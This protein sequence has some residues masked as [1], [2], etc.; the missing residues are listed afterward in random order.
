MW[1]AGVV[2]L[3]DDDGWDWSKYGQRPL[4]KSRY[5]IKH[6]FRVRPCD[7][8]LCLRRSEAVVNV[9]QQGIL[10]MIVTD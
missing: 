7:C 9:T 5:S 2:L 4:T 6:Y 3:L 1:D 8:V 10:N